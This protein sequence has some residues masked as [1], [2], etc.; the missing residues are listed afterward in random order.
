MNIK[1][2]RI[3]TLTTVLVLLFGIITASISTSYAASDVVSV[4]SVEIQDVEY[5]QYTNGIWKSSYNYQTNAKDLD[6][7]YYDIDPN[8]TVKLKDGTVLESENGKV[9][10]N[11]KTYS[12][13]CLLYQSYYTQLGVGTHTVSAWIMGRLAKFNVTIVE[14]PVQS[15]EMPDMEFIQNTNGSWLYDYNKETE[16]SDLKYFEYLINYPEYKVT[17]K[18][19]TVSESENGLVEYNGEEYQAEY[20]LTQNYNNQLKLGDNTVTASF[21]GCKT[22]FNINIIESPIQSVEIQPVEYIQYTNGN[23]LCDDNNPE[24][25]VYDDSNLTFS[26]TLKD[27]TVLESENNQVEYNGAYYDVEYALNQSYDNQLGLG[28][29]TINASIMGYETSFDLNI[30]ESPVQ[31]VEV[32][33]IEYVQYTNGDWEGDED[34]K[35]YCYYETYPEFT[36]TFKDGTVLE[37]E[38]GFVEYNGDFYCLDY[39]YNQSYD[40]QF[41]LGTNVIYGYV[42][43]YKTSINVNIIEN[44]G[45]QLGDVNGDGE[46]TVDDATSIQM[47]LS[48]VISFED[49][50]LEVADIN[51]DGEVTVDDATMLQM[52]L[53]G[54]IDL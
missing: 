25:Y 18:D 52:Y 24:Y 10:Y 35:Y 17:F 40:N 48:D 21:M 8:F 15:V 26:V 28:E 13:T 43:G 54:I 47:Y 12:L 4:E 31:S 3:I 11:N 14:S 49:E 45:A 51:G 32:Q 7:Y 30:V 53:A 42:I 9:D 23:W 38:E 39:K 5:I 19:G 2:K 41:K 34:S 33:D 37:S 46:V 20:D 29:H 6:Y 16:Q 1:M 50:Q 36:V 22:S 44:T 27:G